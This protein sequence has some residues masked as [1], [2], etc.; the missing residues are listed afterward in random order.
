MICEKQEN[1]SKSFGLFGAI[2]LRDAISQQCDTSMRLS[3]DNT[4][5]RKKNLDIDT[6]GAYVHDKPES[7]YR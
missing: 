1:G 7:I 5:N 2:T 3:W 6:T 4:E